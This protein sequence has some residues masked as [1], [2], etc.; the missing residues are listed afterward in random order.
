ME[1]IDWCLLAAYIVPDY[2]DID[3][4]LSGG[5][6]RRDIDEATQREAQEDG[7]CGGVSVECDGVSE[8]WGPGWLEE[9]VRDQGTGA[10]TPCEETSSE[11]DDSSVFTDE[12]LQRLS[13]GRSDRRCSPRPVRVYSVWPDPATGCVYGGYCALQYG[14][15]E[16]WESCAH[17]P[18]FEGGTLSQYHSINARRQQSRYH[19]R[20]VVPYAS[21]ARWEK[22]YKCRRRDEII[23]ETGLVS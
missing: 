14:P 3:V 9:D 2:V 11:S 5:D 13:S 6:Y 18:L 22:L 7:G 10:E 23:A 21:R 17:P 15:I 19:G 16:E 4:E 1:E 8:N 12:D 20:R